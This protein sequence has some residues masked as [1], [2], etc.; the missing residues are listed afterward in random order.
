MWYRVRR[1]HTLWDRSG[2]TV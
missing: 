2:L 1:P